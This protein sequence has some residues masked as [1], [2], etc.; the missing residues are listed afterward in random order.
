LA[1]SF[2][3]LFLP[4]GHRVPLIANMVPAKP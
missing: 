3:F 2:R 1:I 4:F